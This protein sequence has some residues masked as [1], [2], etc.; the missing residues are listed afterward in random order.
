MYPFIPSNM[1]K[2]GEFQAGTLLSWSQ[3]TVPAKAVFPGSV[4][5]LLRSW[6]L[7]LLSRLALRSPGGSM[8]QATRAGPDTGPR[9]SSHLLS[10]LLPLADAILL[11][12]VGLGFF[13]RRLA[14]VGLSTWGSRPGP[15]WAV[16]AASR[17]WHLSGR[18]W[19]VSGW[20]WSVKIRLVT[21]RGSEMPRQW[22]L[23]GRSCYKPQ[24][25][26]LQTA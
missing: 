3:N 10:V 5:L 7:W 19:C 18:P 26:E 20:I 4:Y 24:S 12:A 15:N 13:M 1:Q 6:G 8:E 2:G 17:E 16:K 11:R 9:L 23:L 22:G 14:R 25:D 21:H